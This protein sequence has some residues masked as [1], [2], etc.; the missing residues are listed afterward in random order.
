MTEKEAGLN[1][2]VRRGIGEAAYDSYLTV[3]KEKTLEGAILD[4]L[5][6]RYTIQVS[7]V[8]LYD[9]IDKILYVL[10][11]LS[12]DKRHFFLSQIAMYLKKVSI[13]NK[14]LSYEVNDDLRSLIRNDKLYRIDSYEQVQ[15]KQGGKNLWE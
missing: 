7:A 1:I 9:A 14:K 3:D 10:D 5:Q 8:S 11:A 2:V 4:C 13:W 12:V 15:V 6:T